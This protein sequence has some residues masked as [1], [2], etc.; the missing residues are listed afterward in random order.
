MSVRVRFGVVGCFYR[1]LIII[2]IM[3]RQGIN[4]IRDKIVFNN[5][6]PPDM[7]G[8]DI[9]AKYWKIRMY[10]SKD[11]EGNPVVYDQIGRLDASGLTNAIDEDALINFHIHIMEHKQLLLDRL[12]REKGCLAF[13]YEIKVRHYVIVISSDRIGEIHRIEIPSFAY[14]RAT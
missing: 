6:T 11:L 14:H 1:H 10:W 9:V 3:H 12:S 8:A 5:W 7:P 4:K 2:V 13:C